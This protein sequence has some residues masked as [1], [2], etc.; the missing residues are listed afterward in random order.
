MK[1][2]IPLAVGSRTVSRRRILMDSC[3]CTVGAISIGTALPASLT[4]YAWHWNSYRLSL[5]SVSWRVLLIA[6][7]AGVIGKAA[8][9]LLFR[10]RA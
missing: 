6:F 5:G 8:G 2:A 1:N 9:M 10:M 4:W 3:G 7:A